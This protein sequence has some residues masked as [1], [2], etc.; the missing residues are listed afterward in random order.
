MGIDINVS[1]VCQDALA[2]LLD[3]I[4]GHPKQPA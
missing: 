4:E 3:R 2:D 1:K